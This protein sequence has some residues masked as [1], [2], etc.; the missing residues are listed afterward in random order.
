MF[1]N[2]I[3]QSPFARLDSSYS[4]MFQNESN[5]NVNTYLEVVRKFGCAIKYMRT[6]ILTKQEQ[7][8]LDAVNNDGTALYYIN[9]Q[10]QTVKI[11]IAAIKQNSISS[12]YVKNMTP[13]IKKVL[14]EQNM[15]Y[16]E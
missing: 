6:D 7:V 10:N 2:N 14:V 12:I 9:A 11:C 15:G 8:Y 1:N 3:K 4:I 13:E 16:V 5:H